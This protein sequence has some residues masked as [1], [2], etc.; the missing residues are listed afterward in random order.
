ME[1]IEYN[2]INDQFDCVADI[3]TRKDLLAILQD[4]VEGILKMV[5][6]KDSSSI[7][8]VSKDVAG[9]LVLAPTAMFW[10]K[11]IRFLNGAF[12]S[13]EDQ[14]RFASKFHKD[15]KQYKD[16][17]K[18][19]LF[20]ISVLESD[21]KTD[22]F[23]SLTRCFLMTDMDCPLYFRLAKIL[24]NLT[25]DELEFLKNIDYS[26]HLNNTAI[27]SMLRLQG[28][29]NQKTEN[30]N[31]YYVLSQFGMLI[32]KCSVNYETEDQF[33]I[34]QLKYDQIAGLPQMEPMTTKDIHMM[35]NEF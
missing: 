30:D 17:V 27:V 3:I 7:V 25:S 28:L 24:Q 14:V 9:L 12:L 26:E 35:W 16:F 8:D 4:G 11:M 22:Y 19:Q 2:S 15:N 20:V 10:S 6:F 32:K 23:A 29:I 21:K 13:Y 31:T 5:V 18:K 34:K 33:G 1:K